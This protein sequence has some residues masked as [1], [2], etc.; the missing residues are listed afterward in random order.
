M[1]FTAQRLSELLPA[2]YRI[3]DIE[4][5]SR[6]PQLLTAAERLELK[7]LE[8]TLPLT[9]SE[10]RRLEEL[11]D[12]VTRGPL[13]ALL[14]ALAEQIEALEE[15]LDQLYDDL[16]I[17]TCADW[18][19][20][21][22]GDLIGYRTLHGVVP[23]VS[24]RRAEVA[25]TI[26]FRRRKGTAAMLEQ[27]AR[28]VTGWN[29][30]AVEFFEVLA[31]TQHMNHRRRGNH[32][33]PD[34]R[35]WES[36]ERLDTAFNTVSHTV[37]V[38]SAGRG[39]Y[40]IPN[41]GLFLWRLD[42][43]P[44]TKSPAVRVD[45]R[46]YLFD[47]RGIDQPLVTRPE[48]EDHV[49][50]IAEPLNVPAPISRR[51]LDRDLALY[52]DTNKSLALFV[53]G[54][55]I[56]PKKIR[57]CNLDDDGATWA[58]LPTDDTYVID[59]E[60]GRIAL[61]PTPPVLTDVRVSYCYAFG[62]QIGGGEYERT[63]SFEAEPSQRIVKVPDDHP[64][65]QLALTDLGGDGVVEITDSGRY[66][67]PFQ[68]TASAG[69]RIEIRGENGNRPTIVLSAPLQ[70]AGGVGSRVALNG[71]L[72]LEQPIEVGAGGGNALAALRLSHCTLVPGRTLNIDGTPKS[73]GAPSVLVELAG[74]ALEID[75]SIVGA[76]RVDEHATA[77]VAD[78]IVDAN[79]DTNAA[80]A[81]LDD[82]SAG[83]TLSVESTTIVGKVHTAMLRMA[84]NS[85]FLS[86]VAVADAF[87]APVRAVR[88]QEG[89]VRFSYLPL[90]SR[91][92]RRHRCQ[93]GTAAD[94]QRVAPSFTSLS[95]ASGAYG[96]L[97]TSTPHEIRRGAEDEGEMG[98]FHH[99]HQP[100]READLRVRLDEYLRVGLQAGLF[101][102]S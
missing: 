2:V 87:V 78:S 51:I 81:A 15:N 52:Y 73:P 43:N 63:D 88:K 77:S 94:E 97:A 41:V 99:L 101:Y 82:V 54:A 98:A 65:I 33:G 80:Y 25:H 42:A 28:D 50:H 30:R 89:C 9:A 45:D 40:N 29:A 17:E 21:Y 26:G 74:A 19:I 102:E 20:P 39:R 47:P 67:A 61:P 58:H 84:S 96:Q 69:K 48:T 49:S 90:S 32:Y 46:R 44:L 13:R 16:F 71:L 4:L 5:A 24:S 57:V 31:T 36:L 37:D 93:P 76:L 10:H 7:T 53:A 12:R 68:V 92:P 23:K 1:S 91:V 100:Q 18:A 35:D 85:L 83:G 8:T 3:R 86:R 55:L 38:R 66:T 59:P 22:V 72:I 56:D 6:L 14:V 60:R 11:R 27:L 75:R 34:L 62:A 64:T 70:V 79:A 95:S